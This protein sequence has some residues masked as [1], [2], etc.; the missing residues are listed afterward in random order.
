MRNKV[1]PIIAL[2]FLFM[3][4][5]FADRSPSIGEE[6]IVYEL[7]AGQY[8]VIY[9]TYPDENMGDAEDKAFAKIAEITRS[10]GFRYFTIDEAKEV[11][12]SHGER[13]RASLRKFLSIRSL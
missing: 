4:A 9:L 12:V 8:A 3:G 6:F 5:C 11:L 13:P 7:A 10:G 2:F 1:L